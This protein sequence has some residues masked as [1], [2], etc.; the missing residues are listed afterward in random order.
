[1]QHMVSPVLMSAE[2]QTGITGLMQAQ[3]FRDLHTLVEGPDR[4]GRRA[5]SRL[6]PGVGRCQRVQHGCGSPLVPPLHALDRFWCPTRPCCHACRHSKG[7]HASPLEIE[8]VNGHDHAGTEWT[9]EQMACSCQ[10]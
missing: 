4:V 1:M 9:G 2:R 10:A 5:D 7:S 6:V 3:G 8:T